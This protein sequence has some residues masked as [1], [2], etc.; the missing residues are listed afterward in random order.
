[1]YIMNELNNESL[2]LAYYEGREWYWLTD[3]WTS[4]VDSW[5]IFWPPTPTRSKGKTAHTCEI[6]IPNAALTCRGGQRVD[7]QFIHSNGCFIWS[8]NDSLKRFIQNMDSFSN[9]ASLCVARKCTKTIP[10]WF[11]SEIN[12]NKKQTNKSKKCN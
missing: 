8:L 7:Y 10:L 4:F 11:N 3:Q 6:C 5:C 2:C 12:K 1:M 9:E